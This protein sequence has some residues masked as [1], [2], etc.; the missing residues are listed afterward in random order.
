MT[1]VRTPTIVKTLAFRRGER[2]CL[3]DEIMSFEEDREIQK[4][5]EKKNCLE[6]E[7][8]KRMRCKA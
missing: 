2:R 1:R 8:V 5:S 4:M 6:K 3:E 7:S